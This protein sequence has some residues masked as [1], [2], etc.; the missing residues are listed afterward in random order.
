MDYLHWIFLALYMTLAVAA[1][2]TILLDNRQPA[3]TM[4]WVLVLMFL[5]VVGII[6][7]FFFGQNV[8]KE[9]A[10]SQHSLDQL[11]RRSMLESHAQASLK[12]PRSTS[13]SSISLAVR[14]LPQ[15]SI[16]TR[17]R[18]TSTVMSSSPSCSATSPPLA[19]IS[20]STS[21]SSR[22]TPWGAS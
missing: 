21:S 4:A 13:A 6:L 19:T 20:I 14:I 8:R 18:S 2:V 22:T 16:A 7:Y 17:P 15:L 5:P 10:I 11:S 3:K 9:R 12:I 1:M